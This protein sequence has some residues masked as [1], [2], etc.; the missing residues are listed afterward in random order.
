[1]KNLLNLLKYY[2]FAPPR[3]G[4]CRKASCWDGPNA[5]R[6]MMNILSPH[7]PEDEFRD[8]VRWMEKRGCDT[9]HVI[10]VNKADGEGAGYNCA[11]DANAAKLARKRITYLRKH[12][13]AVVPW[14]ITDD[15]SAWAKD[16]FANAA[17]RVKALAKAGLFKDASYVV[18]GLEMDEYG[19]AKDWQKVKDALRAAGWCG[20]V[21]IHQR[22]E[23][24][25][26]AGLG[27]IFL[28][29]I[30][31]SK[32]TPARVAAQID[33]IRNH[34]GKAAVGFEY[35][36]HPARELAQAA[37]SAGAFAVGNW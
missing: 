28:G 32:A 24:Y 34:F 2:L 10:L 33:L 23:R 4:K 31:P 3:W 13:F 6:R 20:K 16:L 19:S 35:A 37:L 15:S 9:A 22:S 14:I 5:S 36:R 25:E 21:G 30:E 8:R 26:F 11:T 29:Q 17:G 18:L 1:M 7:F 12:G 27:D